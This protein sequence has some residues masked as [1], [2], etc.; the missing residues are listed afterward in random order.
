MDARPN[1]PPGAGGGSSGRRGRWHRARYSERRRP[2]TRDVR[3]FSPGATL[4][5]RRLGGGSLFGRRIWQRP[6]A[7]AFP[8]ADRAGVRQSLHAAETHGGRGR[9]AG[10]LPGSRPDR[11]SDPLRAIWLGVDLSSDNRYYVYFASGLKKWPGP[12]L[13]GDRAYGKKTDDQNLSAGG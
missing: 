13:N 2:A 4:G 1:R 6:P 3:R 10:M 5:T 9:V 11:H 12:T 8:P 7:G